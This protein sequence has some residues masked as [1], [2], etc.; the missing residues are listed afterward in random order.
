MEE[1]KEFNNNG[2]GNKYI[3][4][5]VEHGNYKTLPNKKFQA[6]KPYKKRDFKKITAFIPGKIISVDVQKGDKVT[7]ETCL[8]VLEAMKMKNKLFPSLDGIVKDVYVKAGEMVKKDMVLVEL[9]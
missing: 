8:V 5:F 7:T 9:E 1:L 6:R 2:S 4:L 3:D